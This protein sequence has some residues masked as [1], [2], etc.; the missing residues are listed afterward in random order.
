VSKTRRYFKKELRGGKKRKE[1]KRKQE[2]RKENKKT[3]FYERNRILLKV[4]EI[5]SLAKR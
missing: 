3:L 4:I 2:N 5:C 1:R